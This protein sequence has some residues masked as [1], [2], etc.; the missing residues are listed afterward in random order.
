M[1]VSFLIG[2]AIAIAAIAIITLVVLGV[3]WLK[4]FIKKKMA[5]KENHKVAFADTREIVDDYIKNKAD[6][7]DEISMDD[8]E[9]MC[10]DTPYVAACIDNET[11]EISGYEAVKA[12]QVEAGLQ[13]KLKEQEGMLVFG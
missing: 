9:R 1:I 12:E 8:L 4:D 7:S 11:G 2:L 10:N 3:M 5:E 6:N 13:N